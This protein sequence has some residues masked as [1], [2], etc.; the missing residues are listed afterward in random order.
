MPL[1]MSP[2]LQERLEGRVG[3]EMPHGSAEGYSGAV[4]M[5]GLEEESLRP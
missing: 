3:K 1:S 5:M 4:V 2:C